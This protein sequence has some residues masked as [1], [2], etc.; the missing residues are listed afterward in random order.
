MSPPGEKSEELLVSRLDGGKILACKPRITPSADRAQRRAPENH[1]NSRIRRSISSG[2]V[3]PNVE[4]TI[5]SPCRFVRMVR[6]SGEGNGKLRG[7]S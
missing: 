1:A 5:K 4:M 2:I 3:L 7:R 6:P